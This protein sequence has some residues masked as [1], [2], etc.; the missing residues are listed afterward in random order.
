MVL[1]GL[2]FPK[3]E[4]LIRLLQPEMTETWFV[5]VGISLSFLAGKQ[6]RRALPALQ[7]LG[8]EWMH[9]LWHEPRRLFR[10]YVVHGLPFALRRFTWA[11]MTRL[12]GAR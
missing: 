4:R 8:L 12:S 9:R 11:L 3:R 7:R 2:G 1:I 10:R 6:A 5:G